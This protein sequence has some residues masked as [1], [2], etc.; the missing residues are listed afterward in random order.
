MNVSIVRSQQHHDDGEI[1]HD[2]G[3]AEARTIGGSSLAK[4]II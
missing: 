4:M 1:L 3:A 2:V